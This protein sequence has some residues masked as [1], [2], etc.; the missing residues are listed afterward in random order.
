MGFPVV[1]EDLDADWLLALLEDTE[2]QARAAER[3]KLRL[4]AQWC[5]LHPAPA[6]A[7]V[8]LWRDAGPGGC[9]CRRAP[10]R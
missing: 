7:P 9:G 2:T 1:V 3:R 4:A 8:A 6:D 10:R 5:V